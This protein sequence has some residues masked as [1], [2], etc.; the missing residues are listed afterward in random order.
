MAYAKCTAQNKFSKLRVRKY[1]IAA[2]LGGY[3]VYHM[4][5]LRVKKLRKQYNGQPTGALRDVSLQVATG[6]IMAIVGAS[7][8]G[9]T[10]LLKL[11]AGLEEPD[12]GTILFNGKPLTPP[13]QQLI[14]GH[15][16]IKLVFQDFRLFPNISVR[17]NM[18]YE[19]RKYIQAQQ[20]ARTAELIELCN[21]QSV[22]HKLP[23]QLSGGELQRAAIARALASQPTLLLLD[24]PFSNLD[25]FFRRNLR[26]ELSAIIRQTGITA[27]VVTHDAQEA[28]T[29]A[30]TIAVL[31]A[32]RLVQ[33]GTPME[34]YE[35]PVS[36]YVANL[37]GYANIVQWKQL[38][39]LLQAVPEKF[40]SASPQTQLCIRAGQIQIRTSAKSD[41]AGK[42]LDVR[43]AGWHAE[44]DV[45][46][47][48]S[49]RLLLYAPVLSVQPGDTL[50]LR[51]DWEKVWVVGK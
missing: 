48:E 28:L 4:R 15:P 43:Y 20:T 7:G 35:Q 30:D 38:A 22:Q 49:L 36:A 17:E 10:T 33:T 8:S 2:W 16:Q 9:K 11:I 50:P 25:A 40:A 27:I 26:S 34:V 23:R 6:E 18:A 12:A 32:G 31:Q 37:F 42:V 5:I 24:E 14:S 19:L 44:V 47:S 45:F 46:V 21:L 13:S 41:F 3:F 51:I 29:L 1:P 39:P